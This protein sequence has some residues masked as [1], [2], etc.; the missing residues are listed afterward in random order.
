MK[1]KKIYISSFGGLK[2][3]NL[4]FEDGLNAVFGEN[5]NGKSTVMAFIKM[6]FYGS[7][8]ASSQISKN[9]R[10]KYTPWDGSQM[11]GSIEFEHSGR[12]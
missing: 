6:M 12:K 1:I 11:A 5:E 7:D 10:K 4:V 9:I 3:F 2:D 8:K